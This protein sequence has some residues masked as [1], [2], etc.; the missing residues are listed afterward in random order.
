MKRG[1]K[2]LF[3]LLSALFLV[4]LAACGNHSATNDFS[5]AQPENTLG[6]P[7]PDP[8][9]VEYT[10]IKETVDYTEKNEQY[11][12]RMDMERTD[13]DKAHYFFEKKIVD[14]QR[15]S[16]IEA[17]EQILAQLGELP[18]VPEICVLTEK[19][20]GS[21]FVVGNRVFL[22]EQD[23]QTHEYV[24]NVLM[25]VYGD[26]TH[27]G[28]AYGYANLLCQ[29]LSW[30]NPVE[31]EFAEPSVVEI[32]DLG[33]LCFDTAFASEEDANAAK[34]LACHFAASCNEE[35]LKQFISNSDT[36][37]GMEA[38]SDALSDYYDAHGL[39]YQP[40][41]V[42]YGFGGVSYD[43]VVESDIGTFYL[44]DEWQDRN[45]Q[46]NPLVSENFLHENYTEIREFFEINLRQMQQLRDTMNMYPYDDNISI[47]LTDDPYLQESWADTKTDQL[48]ILSVVSIMHEYIH[49]LTRMDWIRGELW[50]IEGL[51]RYLDLRYDY[52]GTPFTSYDYSNMPDSYIYLGAREYVAALNRPLDMAIDYLTIYD[53]ICYSGGATNPNHGGGYIAGASFISYLVKQYGEQTV[54]QAIYCGAEPLPRTHDELVADWLAY[55]DETYK[56]YTKLEQ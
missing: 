40:T 47:L 45:H 38:V 32:C 43:Y 9:P 7:E 33:L 8:A 4:F 16:C 3:C 25:A 13:T 29:R 51:A 35:T 56:E 11:S 26:F 22:S 30:D 53:L 31:G 46:F 39:S 41:N 37:E 14:E 15:R 17:T 28:L 6:L 49:A 48:Y 10:Y 12:F 36:T 52:Y 18:D 2:Y 50:Q 34:N 24:I 21:L 42:R 1:T 23:W 55:L 20:Y 54:F 5:D 27:Y 19:S 44:C